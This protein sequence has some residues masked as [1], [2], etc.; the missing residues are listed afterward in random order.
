MDIMARRTNVEWDFSPAEARLFFG[1]YTL[2]F[3]NVAY[4]ALLK[5]SIEQATS[6]RR[7]LSTHTIDG[8]VPVTLPH[9]LVHNIIEELEDGGVYDSPSHF[10]SGKKLLYL[11]DDCKNLLLEQSTPELIVVE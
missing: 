8:Q 11:V 9:E 1:A 4:R 6:P 7:V 3:G 10:K 2:E 5:R